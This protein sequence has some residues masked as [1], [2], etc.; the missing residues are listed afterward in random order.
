MQIVFVDLQRVFK[1]AITQQPVVD[2][3]AAL[4]FADRFMDKHGRDRGI[5]AARKAADDISI[6]GDCLADLFDLFA[7]ETRRRPVAFAAA[8]I[9]EIITQYFLAERR[10]GDLWMKLH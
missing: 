1:F 2:E 9:E 7:D 6:R 4:P 3:D 5:D 8:Y 10:V